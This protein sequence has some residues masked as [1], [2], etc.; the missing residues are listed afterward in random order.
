[1]LCPAQFQS[2]WQN[3]VTGA[4]VILTQLLHILFLR[5]SL[6]R[7]EFLSA[8]IVFNNHQLGDKAAHRSLKLC[9]TLEDSHDQ[10]SPRKQHDDVRWKDYFRFF[11]GGRGIA[12]RSETRTSQRKS[13]LN[14]SLKRFQKYKLRRKKGLWLV[15][16]YVIENNEIRN[17]LNCRKSWS[18]CK[19]V[20]IREKSS[21]WK[22]FCATE[23]CKVSS[24][25]R[26]IT[27]TATSDY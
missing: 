15:Y 27:L 8:R 5:Y 24:S 22:L 9:E 1:M 23:M 17:H 14:G 12:L 7:C 11:R 20:L 6:I 13:E 26:N 16:S 25:Y 19:R 2:E 4:Q 10:G 21:S 18:K 3:I